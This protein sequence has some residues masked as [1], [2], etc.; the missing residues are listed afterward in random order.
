[1][2]PGVHCTDFV[3]FSEVIAILILKR[4]N[5]AASLRRHVCSKSCWYSKHICNWPSV[6]PPK[7][8]NHVTQ[9]LNRS[10]DWAKILCANS[11]RAYITYIIW[12]TNPEV[13][14]YLILYIV[15]FLSTFYCLWCIHGGLPTL[16]LGRSRLNS[17][18]N[19]NLM[20]YQRPQLKLKSLNLTVC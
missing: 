4:F 11:N 14:R 18:K 17:L 6:L 15:L 3:K 20:N 13:T 16:I 19:L 2:K 12:Y 8:I 1:M 10:F 5:F 9:L 7:I